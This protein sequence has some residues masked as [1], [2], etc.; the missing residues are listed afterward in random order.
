MLLLAFQAAPPEAC[1]QAFV[2]HGLAAGAAGRV[3]KGGIPDLV[4][5]ASCTVLWDVF[6]PAMALATA[7]AGSTN[8]SSGLQYQQ[9]LQERAR[10]LLASAMQVRM[11]MGAYAAQ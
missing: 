9:E 7:A 2:Q 10:L 6:A 4:A 3:L 8:S 5:L 1:W 11:C